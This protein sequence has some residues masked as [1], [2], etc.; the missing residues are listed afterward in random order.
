MTNALGFSLFNEGYELPASLGGEFIKLPEDGKF[1]KVQILSPL[2]TGY[3]YWLQ[4]GGTKR[5]EQPPKVTPEDIR[6]DPKTGKPDSVKHFWAFVA[7]D[8]EAQKV[9][10]MQISQRSIQEAVMEI[11]RAGDFNLTDGTAAVRIKRTGTGMQNTKY[12]VQ[13]VPLKTGGAQPAHLE[14]A[15]AI[16]LKAVMFRSAED[17]KPTAEQ[18]A[19]ALA[20]EIM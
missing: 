14:E 17:E 18:E 15:A 1:V 10:I 4:A 9:G 8:V 13:A 19:E 6:K 7:F 3:E 5:M 12:M 16:D 2:V 11:Y 20:A